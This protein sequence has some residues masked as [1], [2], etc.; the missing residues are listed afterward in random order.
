MAIAGMPPEHPAGRMSAL[1]VLPQYPAL[2]CMATFAQTFLVP[3]AF[4]HKGSANLVRCDSSAE[5]VWVF[6][7]VIDPL[8]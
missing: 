1:G 5:D 8:Y 7:D 2:A 4:M 6:Y 3:A